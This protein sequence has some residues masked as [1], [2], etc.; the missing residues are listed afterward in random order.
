MGP[1]PQPCSRFSFCQAALG[2]GV[3]GQSWSVPSPS[4]Q[5]LHPASVR[6][7]PVL[8]SRLSREHLAS[9][10]GVRVWVWEGP[11]EVSQ[12]CLLLGES[13]AGQVRAGEQVRWEAGRGAGRDQ[14]AMTGL[15]H[16][17]AGARRGKPATRRGRSPAAAEL[18]GGEAWTQHLRLGRAESLPGTCP[19]P[20]GARCP[21]VTGFS[22]F[23][24][25]GRTW[26]GVGPWGRSIQPSCSADWEGVAQVTLCVSAN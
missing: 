5:A 3:C 2:K 22:A 15:N 19:R 21:V 23:R 10:A 26:T 17:G 9:Q 8:L 14:P 25:T 1:R 7:L 13:G 20:G 16:Q 11:L 4:P 12:H 6:S 24:A 18:G